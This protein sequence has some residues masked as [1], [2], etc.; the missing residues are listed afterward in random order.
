[1]NEDALVGGEPAAELYQ[2]LGRFTTEK[3]GASGYRLRA[4]VTPTE[5]RL[6][7]RALKA[8]EAELTSTDPLR[9]GLR[10]ELVSPE[11]I[12]NT[13]FALL[14]V[15]VSDALGAESLP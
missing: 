4:M 9:L 3:R 1:M 8:I 10:P 2:V 12:S 13:A 5:W 6:L 7:S 15:R 14:A 11:L